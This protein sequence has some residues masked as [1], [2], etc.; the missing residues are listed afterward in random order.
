MVIDFSSA[1]ILARENVPTSFVLIKSGKLT[2]WCDHQFHAEL[3][4]REKFLNINCTFFQCLPI[5]NDIYQNKISGWW[6]LHLY[7]SVRLKA[8]QLYFAASRL[9]G[10]P[11]FCLL[12]PPAMAANRSV[13]L[14]KAFFEASLKAKSCHWLTSLRRPL[15][16]FAWLNTYN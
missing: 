13:Q 3:I 10:R 1:D 6:K 14:V 7:L 5:F 8:T 16:L 9:N 15:L 12:F 11:L 4:D 2:W